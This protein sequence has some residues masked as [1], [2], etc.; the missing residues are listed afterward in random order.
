M[1]LMCRGKAQGCGLYMALNEV[2]FFVSVIAG[3]YTGTCQISGGKKM[4]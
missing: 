3:G 2:R 4:M 1:L